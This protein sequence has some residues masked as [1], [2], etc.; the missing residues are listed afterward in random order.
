VVLRQRR[1]L[2]RADRFD[3]LH[4]VPPRSMMSA[5]NVCA[6]LGPVSRAGSKKGRAMVRRSA[7]LLGGVAV[8]SAVALS[9]QVGAAPPD[10]WFGPITAYPGV[11][12]PEALV[13][14]DVT[15]DG[16]VDVVVSQ[17]FPEPRFVVYPGRGDGSL[18]APVDHLVR[19]EHAYDLAIGDLDGDG[20]DDV[21]VATPAVEVYRQ[22]ADGV[23]RHA[24]TTEVFARNVEIGDVT[25]DGRDDVVGVFWGG[26]TL[27][28]IPQTASGGLGAVVQRPAPVFQ[29]PDVHLVDLDRDGRTDV[30][31]ASGTPR[32]PQLF[33]YL[34]RASGVLAEPIA[35]V[36]TST[37][38]DTSVHVTGVATGDVD[39]DDVVD[40]VL[41]RSRNWPHA[42]LHR[43]EWDAGARRLVFREARARILDSPGSLAIADLDGDGYD[44]TVVQHGFGEDSVTVHGGAATGFVDQVRLDAPDQGTSHRRDVVALADLDRDGRLDLA[45]AAYGRGVWIARNVTASGS[46]PT[47]TTAAPRP[48]TTTTTTPRPSTTTT[49][50]PRPSTTTT[51]TPR[52]STTTTT[53]PRPSTD[54][55]PGPTTEEPPATTPGDGRVDGYWVA[56]ADGTVHAFG[57]PELGRGSAGVVDIEASATGDGY[58]ILHAS[59]VV[60]ARGDAPVLAPVVMPDGE[61]ATGLA[62]SPSGEGYWIA[63]DAGTVIAV[64]DAA[65]LGDARG[66]PLNSPV[67]DV[68]PAASGVGYYLVAGDGGIFTFGSA[69]FAGSMGGIPLRSPVR[70]I[71][72]DADGDGYWLV[73]G[74][75]GV[76]AFDAAFR[77]S[78]G[79]TALVAPVVGMVPY[80]DGYLMV[81][82]DGGVFVFSDRPFLGS[83]GGSVVGSPAVAVAAPP[84][85]R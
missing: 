18:A 27:D 77:G 66:L 65:A 31:V 19:G 82:A 62:R 10:G 51:T 56:S 15:G 7:A 53:A 12:R 40:L 71:V 9:G 72:P 44:D 22:G 45:V 20:R 61:R 17:S 85:R 74:D 25:G 35:H 60:E 29:D 69:R 48:S 32:E 78:M 33:V 2:V 11:E 41:S 52:P 79:G 37:T 84:V 34:Q 13:T 76:F 21:A 14:G 38:D 55:V 46:P 75:G 28:V 54:G 36:V 8:A 26:P 4:E 50:T 83:L 47:P 64:G 80:G 58:W 67:L 3:W 43:F 57:R 1:R 63:T 23:L 81:A 73:A 30:V 24:A 49:T 16:L 5:S 42:A 68:A 70:A 6:D 59:G 39:G